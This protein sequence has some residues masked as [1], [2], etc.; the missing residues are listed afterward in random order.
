MV[1]RAIWVPFFGGG[2]IFIYLV[3]AGGLLS[4][5]MHV[6]SSSLTRGRTQAS[7]IGSPESSPLCPQ[8]SPWV[9]LNGSWGLAGQCVQYR[10]QEVVS[11]WG[12]PGQSPRGSGASRPSPLVG[13]HLLLSAQGES[14][15]WALVPW[16]QP[17]LRVLDA[18]EHLQA[19]SLTGS[20]LG[21]KHLRRPMPGIRLQ[22]KGLGTLLS[23]S[24][25]WESTCGGLCASWFFPQ[26]G[27]NLT[28]IVAQRRITIRELGGCMGPI[29]SSYY[30]NC[31]SLLVGR[32]LLNFLW[33]SMSLFQRCLVPSFTL[34]G[35]EFGFLGNCV[36]QGNRVQTRVASFW[37]PSLIP[38][39]PEPRLM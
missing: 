19:F 11:P 28:D 24:S 3:A 38:R 14:L 7:C 23:R 2:V 32:S 21:P 20:A 16:P 29:W 9:P 22:C 26:V 31:H 6:G 30:G 27:T 35:I 33:G 12:A 13:L 34:C 18:W 1:S 4:C 37:D 8:G 5:G 15:W 25:V 10:L 17:A 39:A 36:S